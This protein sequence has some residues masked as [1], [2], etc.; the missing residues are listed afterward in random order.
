MDSRRRIPPFVTWLALLPLF[1]VPELV[2]AAETAL[3]FTG[4]AIDGPFQLYNALRRIAAGFR[5]GVDFQFFHGIGVPYAH[6]WLFR[7]LGGRFQDAEMAREII[8]AVVFPASLLVFFRAFARTWTRA[9]C[10]TA[11]SIAAVYALK[12]PAL[13]FALNSMVGL[14]STLP[15]LI[16]I[17]FFL[18]QRRSV[19]VVAAGLMLGV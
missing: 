14:R 16:P 12:M 2:V 7:V 15:A 8:A 18:A 17:V 13:L 9:V 1:V 6:Y 10:L 5:P 4:S 3:H 11:G 19:R